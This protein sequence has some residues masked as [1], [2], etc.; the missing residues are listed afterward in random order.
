[1]YCLT[2]GG[3]WP[4]F[5][6]KPSGGIRLSSIRARVAGLRKVSVVGAA[7]F[8]D[9]LAIPR[10]GQPTATRTAT[11]SLTCEGSLTEAKAAAPGRGEQLIATTGPLA[12]LQQVV[13]SAERY[14]QAGHRAL[15]Q[16]PNG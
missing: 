2:R 1:M 3:S 15:I 16:R 10:H 11:L 9:K 7:R 6:K 13:K 14:L 8:F 12:R 4:P 5:L